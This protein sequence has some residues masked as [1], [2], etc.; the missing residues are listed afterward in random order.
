MVWQKEFIKL[1]SL[2]KRTQADIENHIRT[3]S[4]DTGICAQMYE[5]FEDYQNKLE[6]DFRNFRKAT[7]EPVWTLR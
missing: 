3:N 5:E 4:S 1:N 7:T 2:R 6:S